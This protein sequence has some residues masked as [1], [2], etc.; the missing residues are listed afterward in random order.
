MLA[1][2]TDDALDAGPRKN[3]PGSERLCAA[4]G[5]VKPI[6]EMIRFVLDPKGAVVPDLKHR[7]PGRG[8]WVTATREALGTAV[9]RRAFARGMKRDVAV[10][11]DIVGVTDELLERSA[12]DALAIAQKAG[13]VATGFSKV[14]RALA[15]EPVVALIHA[16]E[17][18]PDGVSKL[19]GALQRRTDVAP[20]LVV[21]CFSSTQLDLA[22]GRSNVVHAALNAG[23]ASD[24]FLARTARLDRFRT[25]SDGKRDTAR[26]MEH[27]EGYDGACA[28]RS[29]NDGGNSED[30]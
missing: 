27:V 1:Q 21:K 5:Q 13:L 20:T 8:I 22:L 9:A 23:P 6:A 4:T 17:A 15:G 7:L 10:T 29:H 25:G 28:A 18:A 24:T 26:G 2:T 12:L 19:S 3:A 16:A 11:A 14:E 30:R